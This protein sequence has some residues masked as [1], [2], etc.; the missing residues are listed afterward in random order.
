MDVYSKVPCLDGQLTDSTNASL[1][2]RNELK[3][4]V[5]CYSSYN[6]QS[7][8]TVKFVASATDPNPGDILTYSAS[9]LQ[10]AHIHCRDAT[11][12]GCQVWA[13]WIVY[14]KDL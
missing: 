8:I 9:G 7:V 14:D 13:E 6:K 4:N 2:S 11:S 12:C 10:Q 3:T 5:N 1:P